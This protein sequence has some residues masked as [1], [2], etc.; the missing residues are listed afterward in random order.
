[1][2]VKIC[3]ND[4]SLQWQGTYHLALVDYPEINKWELEK[5]AK[6]VGYEKMYNRKTQI[7]CENPVLK[8]LVC[9]YLDNGKVI[10]P[11]TP[12]DRKEAGTFNVYGECVT[13]DYLS[14]T[15][16]V[17]TAKE[18]LKSGKLL[19]ATKAFGLTGKQLVNDKRNAAGDP[20]DY[21]DYVMFGWSNTTSGYRLAMKRLLERNPTEVDL[22]EAFIPGV[23]FHFRYE[24]IVNQKGY[25][26][27]GYHAAKVKDEVL[28]DLNLCVCII[29]NQNKKEFEGIIPNY[30]KN[31]IHYLD[32]QNDGLVKWNDKVYEKVLEFDG[33][34]R[35]TTSI[36]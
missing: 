10:Y 17:E 30:L 25:V 11:F 3:K 36:L 27:D 8:S 6:F 29:P 19:S 24:T 28:L 20:A 9:Q 31:K 18:I 35:T 1:M 5:I 32:Y 34:V 23:S 26:F 7:E 33:G 22:E 2:K 14:H 13:S 16:T 4:F 15:C 21:F 12:R